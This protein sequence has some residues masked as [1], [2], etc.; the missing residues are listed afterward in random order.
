[1]NQNKF[2][3]LLALS[4]IRCL[5]PREKLNLLEMFYPVKR[6]FSLSRREIE[7]LIGRRLRENNWMPDLFLRQAEKDAITLRRLD[8]K[9]LSI[10]DPEYPEQLKEIFDPPILLYYRGVFPDFGNTIVAIVGTRFPTGDARKAA[11][12][13][14]A[15]LSLKGVCVVSGL[16]RGIDCEA[17]EGSLEGTSSPI[18]VLGNG[19]DTVYPFSSKKLAE[20]LLEKDGVIFSEYL[21]GVPPLKYNFPARNRILSGLSQGV[22][23]IQA[24]KASGALITID[25]ALDQGRDVFVHKV[26]LSGIT[27][28]GTWSLAQDGITVIKCADDILNELGIK[29][30]PENSY[31][32]YASLDKN[33]GSGEKLARMLECEISGNMRFQMDDMSGEGLCQRK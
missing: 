32:C 19:I 26:G 2:I 14:A 4:R 24:P 31:K 10:L 9:I 16:A 7:L 23:V 8:I 30:K 27:G 33:M 20:R 5:R 1:M 21:P 18:A 29:Q 25:Y 17:H 12:N 11:F 6:I 3:S 15:E 13:L 22:V 28:A